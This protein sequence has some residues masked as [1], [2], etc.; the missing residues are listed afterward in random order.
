[1]TDE[2]LMKQ[3]LEKREKS[4]LS[5][6]VTES[7]KS[8]LGKVELK[9]LTNKTSSS[10]GQDALNEKSVTK[11]KGIELGIDRLPTK[12]MFYPTDTRIYI[13]SAKV[14]EIKDFS[15]MDDT[16]PLDVNDKL[17]NILSFCSIWK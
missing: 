14:A 13:R 1:M 8:P 16:N 7:D 4:K 9:P 10:I 5:D 17:N 3:E 2:E 12:G 15:L 11:L 6:N